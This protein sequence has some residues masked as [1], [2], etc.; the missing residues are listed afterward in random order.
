MRTPQSALLSKALAAR[1]FQIAS[2]RYAIGTEIFNS[3]S[4]VATASRT[5]RALDRNVGPFRDRYGETHDLDFTGLNYS[6]LALFSG[7]ARHPGGNPNNSQQ[8]IGENKIVQTIRDAN[9]NGW[10]V[11]EE[12]TIVAEA[13][14]IVG[15]LNYNGELD[16]GDLNIMTQNV[17]LMPDGHQA[18]EAQLRLDMN[19]DD[20]VDVSDVHHWVTDLKGSWI[21][22]A[23]LDGVFD[24]GDFVDVFGAGKYETGE[25]AR[26]SEGDWSGDQIFDS[27]DFIVAFQDGGYESGSRTAVAAVPEPSSLALVGGTLVGILRIVRRRR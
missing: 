6:H 24:S 25:S 27:E 17:T 20:A 5:V 13:T 9:G 14:D 15:D 22:D 26:W 8:R 10:D 19:G 21:G 4:S 16:M 7:N 3:G 12:Y 1:S 18:S 11:I 2:S 23:N